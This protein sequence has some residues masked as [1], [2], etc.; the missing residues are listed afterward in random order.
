M[1]EELERPALLVPS[2][3]EVAQLESAQAAA[4]EVTHTVLSQRLELDEK[5]RTVGMLQKALVSLLLSLILL[6]TRSLLRLISSV[7]SLQSISIWLFELIHCHY[8]SI[9]CKTYSA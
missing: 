9:Q 3:D 2:A 4:S 7:I 5:K 1:N 6:W 8:A